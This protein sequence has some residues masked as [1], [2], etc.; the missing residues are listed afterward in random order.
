MPDQWLAQQAQQPSGIV[1]PYLVVAEMQRRQKMRSGA[2]RAQAPQTSVSD[3]LLRSLQARMPPAQGLPPGSVPPYA[4]APG[5]PPPN[6]SGSPTAM[7]T[8]APGASV[9]PGNM[10][11]PGPPQGMAEGGEVDDDD[12][13]DPTRREPTREEA[14]APL[15]VAPPGTREAVAT[16]NA[17]RQ[18]TGQGQMPQAPPQ[19]GSRL[20]PN[21]GA[22]PAVARPA[23]QPWDAGRFPRAVSPSKLPP[24]KL[25][26]VLRQLVHEAARQNNLDPA[27][28]TGMILAESSGD[29][30]RI[31]PKGA[32]GLMQITPATAAGVGIRDPQQLLNPATNIFTG[33][34]IMSQLVHQSKGNIP[35]ALAGYNAGPGAVA[36]YKGVPPF[37]ETRQYIPRVITL[38]NQ[39]RR[40][41]GQVPMPVPFTAGL[42]DQ[43]N[44][45]RWSNLTEEPADTATTET[46]ESDQTPDQ[47][48][49]DQSAAAAPGS[50][51]AAAAATAPATAATTT[52]RLEQTWMLPEPR[53]LQERDRAVAAAREK[54]ENVQPFDWTAAFDEKNLDALGKY[55][56]KLAGPKPDYSKVEASLNELMGEVKRRMHPGIGDM[57]MNFGAALMASHSPR[58]VEALGEAG[59]ASFKGM[60]TAQADARK[61]YL[62]LLQAGLNLQ[63]KSQ[64]WYNKRADFFSHQLGIAQQAG[65]TEYRSQQSK[66]E[67]QVAS[68]QNQAETARRMYE[69]T[70]Q[71]T[72]EKQAVYVAYANEHGIPLAPGILPSVQLATK[73]PVAEWKQIGASASAASNVMNHNRA[74]V[75]QYS[76]DPKKAAE[77]KQFLLDETSTAVA[78]TK[79]TTK[80]AAEARNEAAMI[81]LPNLAESVATYAIPFSQAIARMPGVSREKLTG[82]VRKLNPDFQESQYPIFQRTE[83]A[84]TSGPPA[85]RATDMNTAIQHMTTLDSAIEALH[86]PD[87]K[88]SYQAL[89]RIA[90]AVGAQIGPSPMLTFLSITHAVAPELTKV[91]ISGGGAEKDREKIEADFD[92]NLPPEQLHKNLVAR[93]HLLQ[94]AINS[95]QAQ[96]NRGTYGR[97]KQKL[98][99]DESRAALNKLMG[100]GVK[101]F[102]RSRL[103]GFVKENQNH[104]PNEAA[105]IKYLTDQ[106]WTVQ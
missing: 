96:Y 55:W 25:P 16:M 13:E 61:D 43:W 2:S 82:E 14:L 19:I 46:S 8:P 45:R 103:A 106:G 89:N 81:D 80:A 52:P 12:E 34:R 98:I 87:T 23:Y 27:L 5:M 37:Q 30:T 41:N 38:T 91:Y 68:A 29:P 40:A 32:I 100:V 73:L 15:M 78:K 6:F 53:S 48:P 3:D 54:L 18:S 66:L 83:A 49:A 70:A 102:P 35:I 90:S 9:P 92:P 11:M 59:A 10:R 24:S 95:M 7:G 88:A 33:A 76:S 51:A 57:L 99:T 97:G 58:F 21:A 71:T 101:I 72:Q 31:S 36:K 104:F 77:A 79:A 17:L 47:T 39:E 85:Q 20:L 69:T 4:N 94:G 22:A 75:D 67:S 1:P 60:Q 56:D 28:L 26:P 63:D 50:A 74:L 42:A 62:Q 84:F 105:A 44:P 65:L 86:N 93:G 64:N